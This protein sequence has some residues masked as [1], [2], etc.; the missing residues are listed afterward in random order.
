MTVNG[1]ISANLEI[2]LD[3]LTSSQKPNQGRFRYGRR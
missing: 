1:N 2:G 3:V